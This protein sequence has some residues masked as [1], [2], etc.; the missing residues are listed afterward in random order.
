LRDLS[1]RLLRNL[2]AS[3]PTLTALSTAL[4]ADTAWNVR[5]TAADTLARF[6]PR[7]EVLAALSRATRDPDQR[8][9]QKARDLLAGLIRQP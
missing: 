6:G 3:E 9:A 5:F 4:A 8:V 7:P 2:S 1:A